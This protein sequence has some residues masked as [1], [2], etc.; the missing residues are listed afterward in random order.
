MRS[1]TGSNPS[2]DAI[3]VSL[4]LTHCL[5]NWDELIYPNTSIFISLQIIPSYAIKRQLQIW[6]KFSPF[7][8]LTFII[9]IW[10]LIQITDAESFQWLFNTHALCVTVN[11]WIKAWLSLYQKFEFAHDMKRGKIHNFEVGL[12]IW[13]CP[14]LSLWISTV[15]STLPLLLQKSYSKL[16]ILWHWKMI[17][18]CLIHY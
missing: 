7:C 13:V 8:F 17:L 11:R 12:K 3:Y 9:W 18:L 16:S 6:Y 2:I 4:Y 14:L 15:I 1:C 10:S 5:N